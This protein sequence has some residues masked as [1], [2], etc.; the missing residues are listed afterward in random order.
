MIK[1]LIIIGI[2]FLLAVV[3]VIAYLYSNKK[4]LDE[5]RDE[6]FFD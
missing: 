2:I 3:A 1:V 4:L 5:L 6:G